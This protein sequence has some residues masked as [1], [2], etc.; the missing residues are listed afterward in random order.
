MKITALNF[1]LRLTFLLLLIA[2]SFV[3]L[4]QTVFAKQTGNLRPGWGFGDTNHVHTGPPGLS[5]NISGNGAGS[6]NVVNVSNTVVKNV[7]QSNNLVVTNVVNSNANTG[8]N[9]ANGNTGGSNTVVT[10]NSS[11]TVTV[12]TGGNSNS[13]N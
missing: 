10:G 4:S 1:H 9:S 2:A 8:G 7:T 11:S 12:V 6:T 3:F 5:V 13:A